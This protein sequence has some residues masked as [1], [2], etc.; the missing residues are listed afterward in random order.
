MA[1]KQSPQL[2]Y[3]YCG[4]QQLMSIVAT[5]TIWLT[6]LFQTNDTREGYEF[7]NAVCAVLEDKGTDP[8]AI[9]QWKDNFLSVHDF[10]Q[11]YGFCMSEAGDLL[12]QWRA[13][14]QN[15]EGFS[16]GFDRERLDAFA[17][18]KNAKYASEGMMFVLDKVEYELDK[19][20]TIVCDIAKD[21]PQILSDGALLHG[22]SP[23]IIEIPRS[24]EEKEK[25]ENASTRL[26]ITNMIF[27]LT[28]RYRIKNIAFSEEKEWRLFATLAVSRV[29]GGLNGLPVG[30]LSQIKDKMGYLKRE[31]TLVPYYVFDFDKK[32][33]IREIILGPR[34]K[35]PDYAIEMFL[36]SHGLKNVEYRRSETPYL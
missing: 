36:H 18:E 5:A 14:A 13:Y 15:G 24:P 20:K 3:H 1:E 35:T 10:A 22:R 11:G 16:L 30:K 2:I 29:K 34:N 6:D 8:T 19:Q 32:E 21:L 33:L 17:K 28:K 27:G 9:E 7:V 12:S 25:I 31:N 26:S 4:M 23:M